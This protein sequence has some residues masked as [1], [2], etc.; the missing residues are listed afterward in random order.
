MAT[1]YS[2]QLPHI[3]LTAEQ[4]EVMRA[5]GRAVELLDDAGTHV[6]VA[7]STAALPDGWTQDDL[8]LAKEGRDSDSPR[9]TTA[10]VLKHLNKLAAQ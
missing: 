10:E 6:G 1:D 2:S 9:Y 8:R 5:A 3:V 4:V 7:S